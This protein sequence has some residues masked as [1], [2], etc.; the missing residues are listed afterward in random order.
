M[1]RSI[2]TD[3]AKTGADPAGIGPPLRPSGPRPTRACA[4]NA[5]KVDDALSD[6]LAAIEQTAETVIATGRT[7]P[8]ANYPLRPSDTE[9]HS[10]ATRS[11]S[12]IARSHDRRLSSASIDTA[13]I[14]LAAARQPH[15]EGR[16]AARLPTRAAP[17]S[18]ACC[19]CNHR[20]FAGV[21]VRHR[22]GR[23]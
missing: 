8:D 10:T 1:I 2:S 22:A 11:T 18:S 16:P 9:R 3:T 14:H 6:H 23:M 4:S 20:D 13:V 5:K 7:A 17:T 21:V 12:I 15:P 19:D